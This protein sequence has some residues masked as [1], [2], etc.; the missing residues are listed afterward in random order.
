MKTLYQYQDTLKTLLAKIGRDAANPS[1]HPHLL[2]TL[3]TVALVA[4]QSEDLENLA[5][6]ILCAVYERNKSYLTCPSI[7]TLN[8]QYDLALAYREKAGG[9]STEESLQKAAG[10]LRNVYRRR[11]SIL[12][13]TNANTIY[14]RREPITTTC[15][16]GHWEPSLAHDG[17]EGTGCVAEEPFGYDECIYRLDDAR[18]G[19]ILT[20]SKEIVHQHEYSVGKNHP[21]TLKSLLWLLAVQV[22]L[23]QEKGVDVTLY[24]ALPRLRNESIHNERL[25]EALALEQK[26][27]VAVSD[28]GEEY[29][30][31][32][33]EILRRISYA[34]NDLPRGKRTVLRKSIEQLEESNEF[35]IGKLSFEV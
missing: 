3:R 4:H 18:W 30:V 31:K 24:K 1:I 19:H 11:F 16:L 13:Q 29:K 14:A 5:F 9:S 17:T 20:E 15:A 34:M 33:L 8:S 35:V 22:L 28:L 26:F 25:V 27:A 10:H 12:S 2:Q 7:L 6:G 32:A 23:R 21:E